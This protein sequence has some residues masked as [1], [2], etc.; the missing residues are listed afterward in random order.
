MDNSKVEVER[1][2]RANLIR[3]FLPEVVVKAPHKKPYVEALLLLTE[4]GF[5]YNSV[6][7]EALFPFMEIL[8]EEDKERGASRTPEEALEKLTTEFSFLT[9]E[10]HLK[11]DE[12]KDHKIESEDEFVEVVTKVGMSKEDAKE[13]WGERLKYHDVEAVNRMGARF[14]AIMMEFERKHGTPMETLIQFLQSLAGNR[15]DLN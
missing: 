9:I 15:Q 3:D 2:R 10:E 11:E 6:P 1:E 7:R 8:L 4:K 12:L 5:T 13:I 14:A